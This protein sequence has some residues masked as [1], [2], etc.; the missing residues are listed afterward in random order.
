MAI[1]FSAFDSTPATVVADIKAAI[2]TSTDWTNPAGDRVLATTTRGADMVVDLADAAADAQNMQLGVYRTAALADKVV[3][4]VAWRDSGGATSDTLHCRVSAGKEHLYFD[5]EGPRAGETNAVSAT[6]GSYRALFFLGDL[7]PYHASDTATVVLVADTAAT[8]SGFTLA[9]V[10]RNY[11]NSASWVPAYLATLSPAMTAPYGAQ[12]ALALTRVSTADTKTY[13]WPYVVVETTA[14]IR[15]RIARAYFTGWETQIEAGPVL[16]R[17]TY[18]GVTYILM[19]AS[20]NDGQSG[21]NASSAF[22]YV[23]HGSNNTSPG[24]VLA[25]P[26]S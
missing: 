12:S 6:M 8:L 7:I 13:L 19:V 20:R 1:A 11:A 3:R 16:S 23:V 18:D 10:G 17:H 26:Y 15:G 5:V 21:N 4:Y 2:L 25:V 9:H 24:A 14:G 22:G